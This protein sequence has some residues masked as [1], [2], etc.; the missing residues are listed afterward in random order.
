MDWGRLKLNQR[1]ATTEHRCRC[2]TRISAG[3]SCFEF[4]GLPEALS[5]LLRD[6]AFCTIHCVRAY[7]LEAMELLEGAAAPDLIGDVHSVYSYLQ[8]MFALARDDSQTA[9]IAMPCTS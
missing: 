1:P 9:G 2:G 5:D 4:E 6:Q 7:L 8:A 3:V